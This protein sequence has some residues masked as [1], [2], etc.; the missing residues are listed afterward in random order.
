MEIF[1]PTE[2]N[3]SI[4]FD[5]SLYFYLLYEVWMLKGMQQG[6]PQKNILENAIVPPPDMP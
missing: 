3:R 6:I 2:K 5:L 4:Y 1:K